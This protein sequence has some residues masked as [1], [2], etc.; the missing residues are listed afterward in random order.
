MTVYSIDPLSDPRWVD[1]LEKHPNASVFHTPAWLKAI[2]DTYGYKSY[3]LTTNA[4]EE[5]LRSGLVYSQVKSWLTGSRL[6]SVPFADHCEPLAQDCRDL[7]ELRSHFETCCSAG[8]LKYAELRPCRSEILSPVELGQFHQSSSFCFH[9]L[10]LSRDVDALFQSLHKSCVRRKIQRATHEGIAIRH[11]SSES[12]LDEFYKL[13]L[14]TR[15][16]HQLPPQ[17]LG[18]FR[19]L[20]Q[21]LGEQADI[22]IASVDHRPIAGIFT[23]VWK[24]TVVYKYGASDAQFHNLGGMP[25]L[26]WQAILHAKSRDAKT[27][28]LGRSDLDN[29]GLIQFKEHLGAERRPLTYYRYTPGSRSA[30]LNDRQS[31]VAKWVFAHLPDACLTAAGN[32][33]Y[34]HMG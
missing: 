11:G 27:F 17:P 26:F 10:N 34:R 6:V 4:P 30:V 15:R 24:N 2:R 5:P 33:L 31:Q 13:L 16:R 21:Y 18:W 14:L 23:L 20:L 1:L 12:L 28:D 19:S 3:A 25:A 8:R 7:V 32:L 22:W 29:P 9:L